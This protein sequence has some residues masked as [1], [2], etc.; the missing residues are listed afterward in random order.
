MAA[1][2]M[3]YYPDKVTCDSETYHHSKIG[4]GNFIHLE[5][6]E[7]KGLSNVG[8]IRQFQPCSKY[9]SHILFIICY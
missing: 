9:Q 5:L 1:R 2:L 4:K 7:M 3:M 8:I 6:K